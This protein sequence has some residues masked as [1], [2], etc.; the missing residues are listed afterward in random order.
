[1]KRELRCACHGE[2]L[3][4]EVTPGDDNTGPCTE[5]PRYQALAQAVRKHDELEKRDAF[6]R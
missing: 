3:G 1:M 4:Y 5:P 6:R 2:L